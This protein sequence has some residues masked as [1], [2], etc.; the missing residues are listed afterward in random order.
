MRR[1]ALDNIAQIHERIDLQVF[2]GLHQRTQDGCLFSK[3]NPGEIV[4]GF[5]RV[6]IACLHGGAD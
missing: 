1:Y 6:A 4:G 2:T 3:L 5:Q